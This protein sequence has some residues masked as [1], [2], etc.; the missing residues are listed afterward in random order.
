MNTSDVVMDFEMKPFARSLHAL[1][2][3][4][5]PS[6][7]MTTHQMEAEAS[8][9]GPGASLPCPERAE[10]SW[11]DQR[12]DSNRRSLDAPHAR[13]ATTG[14]AGVPLQTPITQTPCGPKP[15][16]VGPFL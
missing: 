3:L 10:L 1:R 16:T 4:S 15:A 2:R 8:W 7:S 11:R 13:D 14:P 12:H 5:R 9:P 6:S